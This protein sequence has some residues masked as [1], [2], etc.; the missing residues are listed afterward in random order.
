MMDPVAREKYEKI[1]PASWLD[2]DPELI[3]ESGGKRR[4]KFFAD[5]DGRLDTLMAECEDRKE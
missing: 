3:A 1:V 4:E 5:A 2:A